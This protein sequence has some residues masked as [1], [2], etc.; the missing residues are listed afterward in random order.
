MS[1]QFSEDT[2]SLVLNSYFEDNSFI[3]GVQATSDDFQAFQVLTKEPDAK[4]HPHLSRW[5]NTMKNTP[6]PAT[7]EQEEEEDFDLFESDEEE[8]EEAE[9]LKAQRLAE[10]N[11]RKKAKGSG[12]VEKTLVE[13]QV[14]PW[15]S[16]TD[17][18]ALEAEIRKIEM[19]GLFW[20]ENAKKVPLAFTIMRLD[21]KAI[22]ENDKV[23]IDDLVEKIEE[24]EDY[25]QSVDQGMM[26]TH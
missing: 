4:K 14:K 19:D 17:L 6:Q 9:R 16:D 21:I 12:P 15:D 10:Y 3:G 18:D 24:L 5:Y 13:L 23:S 26:T 8:D 20:C 1:V 2:L 22:V 7:Q 25:V 11:E